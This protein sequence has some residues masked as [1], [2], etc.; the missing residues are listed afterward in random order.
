MRASADAGGFRFVGRMADATDPV[1]AFGVRFVAR[2]PDAADRVGAF[3]A[4]LFPRI[5]GFVESTG[6]A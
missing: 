5:I 6:L 3:G 1:G 2:V 4:L